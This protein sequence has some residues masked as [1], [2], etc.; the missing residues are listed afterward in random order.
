MNDRINL[1]NQISLFELKR[2]QNNELGTNR[3]QT[4]GVELKKDQIHEI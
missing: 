4:H 3:N 2:N 1:I